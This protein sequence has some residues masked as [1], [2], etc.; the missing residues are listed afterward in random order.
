MIFVS[1]EMPEGTT[2][3]HTDLMASQVENIVNKYDIVKD[4]ATNVGRDNPRVYYNIFPSR[5]A[6][7]YAQLLVTLHERDLRQVEPFVARSE[8]HTSELQ[9]RPHLVCRLLLEKNK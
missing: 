3:Q 7:N 4:I 9:S 6:V 8:E 5:Q 2:Y 1:I